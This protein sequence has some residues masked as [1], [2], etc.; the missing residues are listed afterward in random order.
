MLYNKEIQTFSLGLCPPSNKYI[1]T[2]TL[3]FGS[4]LCFLLQARST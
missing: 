3:C 2:R 4:R 1:S